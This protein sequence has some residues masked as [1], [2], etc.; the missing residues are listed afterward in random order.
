MCCVVGRIDEPFPF[1]G[2]GTFIEI[3]QTYRGLPRVQHRCLILFQIPVS[4][5]IG[6][7]SAVCR[8]PGMIVSMDAVFLPLDRPVR[9]A[10]RKQSRCD[11]K[12]LLVKY[13]RYSKY[14]EHRMD[15]C[16]S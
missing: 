11:A 7:L 16:L 14:F 15:L 9:S 2:E 5:V 13:S 6:I 4:L 12:G 3:S 1:R 8:T 10:Q